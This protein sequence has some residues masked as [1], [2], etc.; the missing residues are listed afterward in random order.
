MIGI[1]IVSHSHKLAEAVLEMVNQ[2]TKGQVLAAAAGGVDDPD[3]PFGTDALK[4]KAAIESVF[5]EDGVLVLMDLGSA[6]LSAEMALEFLSPAGREKVVL[7]EAPLVEGAVAAAV[8]AMSGSPLSQVVQEARAALSAKSFHLGFPAGTSLIAAPLISGQS[9]SLTIGNALGLHARPAAQF[10]AT[11]G[12]FE[13]TIQ[14]RKGEQVADA[15]SIN[16]VATLAVRQGET[17]LVTA[18][19]REAGAALLALEALVKA[20]FGETESSLP[21]EADNGPIVPTAPNQLIGVPASPGI[22]IGP[23]FIY[24]TSLPIVETNLVDDPAGEWR[25][26]ENALLTAQQEIASLERQAI[27]RTGT[28]EAAIFTAHRLFLQD[29]SLVNGARQ[30]IFDWK[31]N[32]EAAWHQAYEAMAETYRELE[33]AYMRARAAD[34]LDVGQRVLRLLLGIVP[35]SLSLDEP[36][37][38]IANELTPSETA[39][40]EREKVLAICTALGGATAHS[41]ILARALGIPAVVGLQAGLLERVSVGQLAAVD[42]STGRVWLDPTPDQ[43]ADLQQQQRAW[44]AQV[45]HSRL[46]SQQPA[47]TTDG[48][49]IEIAANIRTV[50]EAQEA[51]QLG[52]EGVGLLRTEFLFMDRLTPPGEE[53][54]YQFYRQV[55][56]LMASRPVIIRTLDVGGDKPIPYFAIAPEAN[57]FLGWRGIRFC[58]SRPELFKSQLRAIL[59]AGAGHN[60]KMMF[61]MVTTLAELRAAKSLF[62]EAKAELAASRLPHDPQME[63]GIMIEVPAAAMIADQLAQEVAFFSIG[64]NDLTQYVMAADRGN[65]NVADLVNGLHPAVLRMIAQT[66]EAAHRAGIWVG[67]CGELA[68]DPLL[69]PL[70]VGLGLDELSMSVPAI[71]AVKD[72]VRGSSSGR[73]Q[74]IA[75][76]A[77]TLDSAQAVQQLLTQKNN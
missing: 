42:G 48:R 9:I 65:A 49:R 36:A 75:A 34:I 2:M 7:C 21:L 16:Q 24:Q 47:V 38:L 17:I 73:E 46:G 54:Q 71:P 15:K 22:A 4:V 59:R 26:L 51:L 69:T 18:S 19:G 25:R 13:A 72:R 8:Q 23:L 28:N 6:I 31:I 66:V 52:A 35:P 20:N 55:V 64:S 12:R 63:I 1:V 10:V 39:R 11:A 62:A 14:I 74:S 76:Y 70:W 61:P 68:G 53:E 50:Q 58:L 30:A 67:L 27:Q 37:V 77:L 3:H 41:A 44:Q 43:L 32:A 5:S 29:P 56:E 33:N 40:L 57:P 60:L 45:A